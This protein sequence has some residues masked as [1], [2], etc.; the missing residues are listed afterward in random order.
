[1]KAEIKKVIAREKLIPLEFGVDFVYYSPYPGCKNPYKVNPKEVDP[2]FTD[3]LNK[4][5]LEAE[6]ALPSWDCPEI[7]VPILQKK[8]LK[9][10][11][12]INFR[13]VNELNPDLPVLV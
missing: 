10:R 6:A 5:W 2:N 11:Y 4:A 3:I 7:D 12:G 9:E 8:I 1:M 13:T